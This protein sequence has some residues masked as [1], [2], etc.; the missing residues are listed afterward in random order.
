MADLSGLVP[1]LLVAGEWTVERSLADIGDVR[2]ALA[3]SAAGG[4]ALLFLVPAGIEPALGEDEAARWG[5][6]RRILRD[7]V[8]GRVVVDEVPSGSLLDDRIAAG[9]P[10][11][12]GLVDEITRR[13]KEAHR[14]GAPHGQLA[15]D[16]VVVGPEGLAV[17][18][19]GLA[20][21]ADASSCVAHDLAGLSRL[22]ALVAAPSTDGSPVPTAEL[23]RLQA[24][25]RSGHLATLRD[26]LAAWVASGG[27]EDD[28]ATLRARDALVRI[29]RAIAG[30]VAGA[31]Q[32]L[33]ANDPLGA[34]ALCREAIRLG[35]EAD[36]EPL[37]H[38]A[39][40]AARA[41]AGPVRRGP[42]RRTLVLAA[43]GGAAV[44][45]V[46]LAAWVMRPDPVLAGRQDEARR[47]ARREGPRVALVAF[48][49]RREH[50]ETGLE[51]VIA[52]RL[53][54]CAAAER[55][56]IGTVRRE[57]VDDGGRP[58]EAD[59]L[60]GRALEALDRLAAGEHLPPALAARLAQLFLDIDRAVHLYRVSARLSADEALA[61]VDRLI[62][63]DPLLGGGAGGSGRPDADLAALARA[64]AAASGDAALVEEA[65]A[66]R[67]EAAREQFVRR[68]FLALHRVTCG[69]LVEA[70]P[71]DIEAARRLTGTGAAGESACRAGTDSVAL[72]E[73]LA[74]SGPLLR[75]GAAI[76]LRTATRLLALGR[77]AEGR[78]EIDLV[79][80]GQ[81]GTT[82]TIAAAW[83]A[84]LAGDPLEAARLIAALDATTLDRL[85][86]AGDEN[87]ARLVTHATSLKP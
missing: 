82:W 78:R 54:A 19:W 58:R 67:G 55:A 63:R 36:A 81:R 42:S 47:L 71:K 57:V 14:A 68:L 80:A 3:S 26:A 2:A 29:E 56:R 7:P 48:A 8:C 15:P 53:A 39:R 43:A 65:R 46:A 16:R 11:A 13:L 35:G 37:L 33:A 18:G 49:R 10:P 74:R 31:R 79:P 28:P 12:A 66:T 45:L 50:G 40:R 86:A 17:A 22:A 27:G 51:E 25:I 77:V 60:A 21:A 44:L 1:G 83:A 87:V 9:T 59:E 32:R 64:V 62:E 34:V 30:H 72:G 5:T 69:P 6:V 84:R 24:A 61:A 73:L 20:R 23:A 38:V 52:E 70:D 76:R 85:R 75:A 41:L 4:R